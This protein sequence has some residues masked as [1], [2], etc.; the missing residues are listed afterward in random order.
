MFDSKFAIALIPTNINLNGTQLIFLITGVI[1]GPIAEEYFFRGFIQNKLQKKYTPFISILISSCLFGSWHFL[2]G[3][4]TNVMENMNL[5][6]II[7]ATVIDWHQ[8]YITFFGGLILGFIYYKSKSIGPVILM[9]AIWN[10]S[11]YCYVF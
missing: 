5:F 4:N 3:F 8:M 11:V 10:L 2:G 1:F 9:H 6:S 7:A